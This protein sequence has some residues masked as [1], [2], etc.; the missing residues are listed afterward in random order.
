MSQYYGG[1]DDV[2]V[3]DEEE[4]EWNGVSSEEKECAGLNQADDC[5]VD[6]LMV[7]EMSQ[8]E[9]SYN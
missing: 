2:A 5:H 4:E 3:Q 8:G 1:M 7:Q 6:C 9:L